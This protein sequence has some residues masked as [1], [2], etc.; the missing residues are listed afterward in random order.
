[1]EKINCEIVK[2]D[3][4]SQVVDKLSQY[5]HS[6]I[7]K[8][9]EVSD[10]SA[11]YDNL[12]QQFHNSEYIYFIKQVVGDESKNETNEKRERKSKTERVLNSQLKC[13]L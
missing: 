3:H 12:F 4:Q 6:E 11:K 13:V 7:N 5:F 10:L 8:I 9:N 1:M 2:L